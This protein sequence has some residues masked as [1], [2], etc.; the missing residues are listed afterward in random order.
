MEKPFPV[1]RNSS[2]PKRHMRLS[3]KVMPAANAGRQPYRKHSPEEK[4]ATEH[5]LSEVR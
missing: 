4:V 1:Y 3:E 2:K 5:A